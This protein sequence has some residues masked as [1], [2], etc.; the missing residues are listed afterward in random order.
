MKRVIHLICHLAFATAI[1]ALVVTP[2]FSGTNPKGKPFVELQGQIVEVQ[3]E[4]STLQDQIDSLVGR[5]NSVEE[6]IDA[7]EAAILSLQSQNDDLQLQINNNA[8]DVESC[9]AQI[10]LLQAEN[11]NLQAQIDTNTGDVA[12]CQTL[13]DDNNAL[14]T[15]LQQAVQELGDLQSQI[16][17]NSALIGMLEQELIDIENDLAM[18]QTIISGNCPP[19]ESIRQ[20]NSDGSVVCEFDDIGVSGLDRVTVYYY[21][22]LN[23]WYS[24]NATAVC[25]S[26]FLVSGGGFR[27]STD[28]ELYNSYPSGNDRWSIYGRNMSWYYQNMFV[29]ANCIRHY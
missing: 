28:I 3:G 21:R 5:V 27:V 6:K 22:Q 16:E 19:G 14:I 8:A 23:P 10:E 7:N 11:A 4:F 26:G 25:P 17:N 2:A 20:V 9:Q 15:S 12:E 29:Y 1:V 18:K 24:G 13:I